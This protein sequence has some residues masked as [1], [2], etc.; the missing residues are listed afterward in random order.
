MQVRHRGNQRLRRRLLVPVA[1]VL[2]ALGAAACF[3]TGPGDPVSR[4][5]VIALINGQR[6]AHG[7]AGLAEDP[8]LDLLAQAWA[9]H[10]AA[11][12]GLAHQDLGGLLQWPVM[13][14][15]QRLSE[16]LF[17]GSGGVDNALTVDM[18]MGSSEH[19]ANILDGSVNRVGIGV[20]HDGAGRTY[21]VADF[22]LR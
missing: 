2:V 4:P 7:M 16:N 1:A 12:G 13:A 19:A 6:G 10:L 21:V 8:Q 20:A 3:P 5:G 18:W 9:I 15:W 22:G 14:G 11:T 17:E